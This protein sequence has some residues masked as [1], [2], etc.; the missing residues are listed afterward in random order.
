MRPVRGPYNQ[1][2]VDLV[3]N[4]CNPLSEASVLDGLVS[5]RLTVLVIAG[6]SIYPINNGETFVIVGQG[7][8][9]LYWQQVR[10]GRTELYFSLIY[11]VVLFLRDR[12][13]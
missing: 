2:D 3:R 8:A 1:V 4:T 9:M 10:D 6:I 7:P 11:H 13:I 5:G 12:S